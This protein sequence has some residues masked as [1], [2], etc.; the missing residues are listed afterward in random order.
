[1]HY[2][3][4]QFEDRCIEHACGSH[5]GWIR[6]HHTSHTSDSPLSNEGYSSSADLVRATFV[7]QHA[8]ALCRY[9]CNLIN[10]YFREG[11]GPAS[12]KDSIVISILKK[13]SLD[14]E[15]LANNRPISGIKILPKI[16]EREAAAQI[17]EFVASSDCFHPWQSGLRPRRSTEV[18][19]VDVLDRVRCKV[20]E[21]HTIALVH[22]NLSAV[23][24]TV[25]H[26]RLNS[27][28]R[29]G[30]VAQK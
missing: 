2:L 3:G 14:S 20:D 10:C 6:P 9:F 1:M 22:L 27:V 26:T 21:G 25:D 7:K 19:A 16:A 8:A 11:F 23:F 13:A 12:L 5:G 24:D 30:G 17:Q 29:M 4:T 28:A 18:A 15:V